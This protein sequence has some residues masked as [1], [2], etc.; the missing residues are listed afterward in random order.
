M[1]KKIIIHIHKNEYE[2]IVY[3]CKDEQNTIVYIRKDERLFIL[4][5]MNKILFFSM[6]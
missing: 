6:L 1:N 2:T 5:S 3:N 4:V